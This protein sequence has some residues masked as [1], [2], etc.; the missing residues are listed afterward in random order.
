MSQPDQP[1]AAIRWLHDDYPA[2]LARA[3]ELKR[4]LVI[5][6]WAPWCHTCLS[7]KRYVLTDPD[8]G[9]W[10]E[11]FVWLAVDTDRRE[12]AEVVRRYPPDFWPTF[13]VIDPE[14]EAVTGRYVGAASV[15]QFQDFLL[16]AEG[17][18][19]DPL[20][21]RLRIADRA[22]AEGDVAAADAGY[23]AVLD[24]APSD[25]ARAPDVL[26]SW[27]GVRY[28]RGDWLGC[29]DL[30]QTWIDA[31]AAGEGPSTADFAYYANACA[32]HLE[33]ARRQTLRTAAGAAIDLVLAARDARL[34]V[35]DRGEALRI[36]REIHLALGEQAEARAA[37]EQQRALLDRASAEAP[38]PQIAMTWAWPRAEVYAYLGVPGELVPDLEKLVEALPKEY[39]PPYRLAWIQLQAGDPEAALDAAKRALALVYGPR[40]A[41]VWKLIADIHA[42]RQDPAEQRAALAKVVETWEA[43]PPAMQRPE[44]LAQARAALRELDSAGRQ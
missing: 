9:A 8:L 43:L 12:N 26:V 42:A 19:A 14:T 28:R 22:A 36:R 17:P 13:L 16:H 44:A 10:A 31:V 5:D 20:V 23:E 7:M 40:K 27:I 37:A 29:A 39:D 21:A 34:T 15:A 33:P 24:A 35:D 1:D 25:W 3:R 30:A 4:P 38:T 11:R 6:F 41:R 2:A 32:E 18:A